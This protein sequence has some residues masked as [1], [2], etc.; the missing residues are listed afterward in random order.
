[1]SLSYNKQEFSHQLKR[2]LVENIL[3]FWMNHVVDKENG[4]FYGAL[5][6][7]LK[8]LNN[9]P[10]FSILTSRM[11]WTFSKAYMVLKKEE[12]LSIAKQAYEYL[13]NV[14]WDDKYG[15]VYWSVDSKGNIVSDRKHSYAQAFVIYGISEYFKVVN[16]LECLT[17]AKSTFEYLEKFVYDKKYDGYLECS[18]RDWKP[19]EDTR[20]SSHALN[21]RKS[22]NTMLHI[23]EAYSNLISVWK[24]EKLLSQHKRILNT[25]IENI[26]DKEENHLKL[27]FD[28][29]W[30]SLS[31]NVSFGHD[32]EASWL[33]TEA[34]HIHE[35]KEL[36][37]MAQNVSIKLAESTLRRAIDLDGGI[38]FEGNHGHLIDTEKEWWVQAEAIVGFYNAYQISGNPQFAEIAYRVWGFI[39]KFVIDRENGDWFKRIKKDGTPNHNRYKAGPWECPYHHSRLCFEMMQRLA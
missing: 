6:N 8:I 21:C 26:W 9:V 23:M 1:M 11:L 4:G 24:D 32:I 7:D 31:G 19:I 22:M 5:T 39:Q 34:V 29:D 30:K 37:K 2:E 16:D 17:Y 13:I 20:M 12:Y 38:F 36:Q 33:L 15:G 25:F 27:F 35:D 10:R 28:E 14:F 18:T 3:P